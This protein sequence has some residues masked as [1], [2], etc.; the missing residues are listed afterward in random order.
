MIMLQLYSSRPEHSKQLL[1]YLPYYEGYLECIFAQRH[2]I[3]YQ[4]SSRPVLIQ[5]TIQ[6]DQ[7]LVQSAI[8]PAHLLS[9][10]RVDDGDHEEKGMTWQE[11][12]ELPS[13]S[14]SRPLTHSLRISS[15][16]K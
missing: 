12:G 11:V 5:H 9:A 1:Q 10:R 15:A 7:L 6:P 3:R 13:R 14:P 4:Y 8:S 2:E 16:S